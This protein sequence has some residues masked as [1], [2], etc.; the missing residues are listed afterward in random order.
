MKN[1]F[2]KILKT[3]KSWS[4]F[5]NSIPQDVSVSGK[6][7][8]LFTKYYFLVEPKVRDDYKNVWLYNEIPVAVREKLNIGSVEHGVDLILEDIY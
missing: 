3:S 6:L 1:L 8:E 2:I 7:F 4:D 5:K